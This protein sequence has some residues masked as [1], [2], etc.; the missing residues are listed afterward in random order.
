LGENTLL[1][2]PFGG[3]LGSIFGIYVVKYFRGNKI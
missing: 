3:L 1:A 2:I